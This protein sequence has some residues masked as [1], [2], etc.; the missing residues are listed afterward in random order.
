[1]KTIEERVTEYANKEWTPEYHFIAEESYIAGATEQ[2]V[3]DMEQLKFLPKLRLTEAQL[4][5]ILKDRDYETLD[6]SNGECAS[7]G[8]T[9]KIDGRVVEI[10][11]E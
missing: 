6:V 8:I 2:K 3:I 9:Y 10:I 1:M 7:D 4:Q 5:K 11:D